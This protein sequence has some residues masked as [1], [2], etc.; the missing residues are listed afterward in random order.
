M[1]FEFLRIDGDNFSTAVERSADDGEVVGWIEPRY[2][3]SRGECV[4]FNNAMRH[5]V[6]QDEKARKRV[7]AWQEDLERSDYFAVFLDNLDADEHRL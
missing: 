3:R 2:D 5:R 1:L 7:A 6:P 4:A